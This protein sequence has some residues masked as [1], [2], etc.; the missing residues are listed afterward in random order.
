MST[1][2]E[3]MAYIVNFY[4]SKKIVSMSRLVK[5]MYLVD[6]QSAINYE[7]LITNVTWDIRYSGPF[8]YEID[9]ILTKDNSFQVVKSN[10][11]NLNVRQVLV[12]K[13]ISISLLPADKNI[14]D[15]ILRRTAGLSWDDFLIQ[16]YDTYPVRTQSRY[17]PIDLIA[18]AKHYKQ[19]KEYEFA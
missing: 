3:I 19:H 6:W 9:N 14:L 15:S 1:L 10:L 18:L 2:K 17:T 16:V 4:T 8:A 5:T 13:H 7:R 12:A 11:P